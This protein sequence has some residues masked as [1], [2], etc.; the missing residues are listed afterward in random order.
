MTFNIPNLPCVRVFLEESRT[1]LRPRFL[2]VAYNNRNLEESGDSRSP[3]GKRHRV[4]PARPREVENPPAAVGRKKM[5]LQLRDCRTPADL[6]ARIARRRG[7]ADAQGF[8]TVL[9]VLDMAGGRAT[10]EPT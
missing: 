7:L 4:E 10:N 3:P 8:G 2:G 1:A 6:Q 5:S 9:A